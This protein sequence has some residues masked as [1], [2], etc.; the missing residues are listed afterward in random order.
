MNEYSNELHQDSGVN[1]YIL[2]LFT[3]LKSPVG[4]KAQF[5]VYNRSAC[6]K[7][8]SPNST[9]CKVV[10]NDNLEDRRILEAHKMYPEY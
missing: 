1:G 6:D 3:V 4:P 10:L 2:T 9:G 8:K 7:S 5:K